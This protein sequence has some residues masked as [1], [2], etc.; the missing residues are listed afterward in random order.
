V[1]GSIWAAVAA[2]LAC[3]LPLASPTAAAPADPDA[4]FGTNGWVTTDFAAE[5]DTGNG[6]AI[7]PDGKLVVAGSANVGTAD[8]LNF[9][10]AVARYLP[11]GELDESFGDDGRVTTSFDNLNLPDAAWDVAIQPDGKVVVVGVATK[12]SVYQQFAVV[13]YRTDGIQTFGFNNLDGDDEARG[14]ELDGTDIVVAGWS[15][16]GSRGRETAI[17]RLTAGGSLD[18]NFGAGGRV[19][20]G[21]DDGPGNDA[22]H[23]LVR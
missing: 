9:D 10:F 4:D 1:T 22:A 11:N 14:V 16:Q 6:V 15:E 3:A 23:D 21:A 17:A 12:L 13:R 8:E 20:T 19:T 7:Q 2:A 5:E 18:S